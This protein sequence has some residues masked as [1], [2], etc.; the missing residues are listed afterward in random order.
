M[1][2]YFANRGVERHKR[3]IA[4]LIYKVAIGRLAENVDHTKYDKYKFKELGS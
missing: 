2:K 1:S 4:N 3:P